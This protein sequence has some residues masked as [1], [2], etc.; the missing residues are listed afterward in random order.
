MSLFFRGGG[1]SKRF[2][3][4]TAI[5]PNSQVGRLSAGATSV[6]TDTSL[7]SSAVWAALRI[8]A[9]LISTLPLD[10]FRRINGL[11]V[12]VG[13]PRVKWVNGGQ[14]IRWDEALYATQ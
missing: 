3:D 10:T 1:Q 11:Q 12:N 13:N 14:E 6:T 8:R 9:N 5:P 2:T 4:M 7:R